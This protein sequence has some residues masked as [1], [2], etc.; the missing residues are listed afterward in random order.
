MGELN[1]ARVWITRSR[2]V[3]A[4]RMGDAISITRE[5]K[6]GEFGLSTS[7]DLPIEET[8]SEFVLPQSISREIVLKRGPFQ[9]EDSWQTHGIVPTRTGQ[10][11][12][13]LEDGAVIENFLATHAPKSS[14]RPGN[15]E[16]HFW[17]CVRNERGEIAA[18]AATLSMCKLI[19]T[20]C[21]TKYRCL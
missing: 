5:S 2:F 16:I 21:I 18:I 4:S 11:I 3:R 19:K 20:S 8:W 6:E 7:L 15:P 13:V 12:E 1:V 9:F 10:P 17:G 14:A